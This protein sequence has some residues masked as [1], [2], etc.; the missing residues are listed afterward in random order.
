MI[1]KNFIRFWISFDQKKMLVNT[2]CK[3]LSSVCAVRFLCSKYIA[4]ELNEFG[5]K[6]EAT[7]VFHLA[8]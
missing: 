2:E 8:T 4:S 1:R 6:K 7:E 5:K 3:Y